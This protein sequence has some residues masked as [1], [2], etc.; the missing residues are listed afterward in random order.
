MPEARDLIHHYTSVETL[1][2]ILS[3][4]RIRLRPLDRMDDIREAQTHIGIPFGKYFFVSCWTHAEPESIPQWNMYTDNMTGVRLSLPKMP[5][6]LRRLKP[7]PNWMMSS[8]GDIWSPLSFEEIFGNS[9]FV[10]PMFLRSE[11][12]A[13]AVRYVENVEEHYG[14]AIVFNKSPQGHVSLTISRPFDLVCLKSTCWSF[15]AEYRF[16]LFVLPSLPV[17]TSGPGAPGFSE[18]LPTHILN[19]MLTGVAP[20]IE[21]LDLEL[22]ADAL[23]QIVVTTGP[24]S[25]EATKRRVKDLV[26]AH[27]PTGHIRES[28]LVGTIRRRT[29]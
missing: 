20:G 9:H 28:A 11:H 24:L 16:F 23:E 2:L 17:P 19:S 3:T 6:K 1:E 12:F 8:T 26:R 5:F 27:V 13:T 10:L 29:K 14:S 15:Q 21:Y 18:I 22:S 4:R 25:T 7:N